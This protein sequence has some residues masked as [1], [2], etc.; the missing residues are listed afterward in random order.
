[1]KTKG[2][3]LLF[4]LNFSF[5]LF[6]KDLQEDHLVV[7]YWAHQGSPFGHVAME[8]KNAQGESVYLSYVMG[9]D[10]QRDLERF[11]ASETVTL[12]LKSDDA[13]QAYK[14][15]WKGG[16]FWQLNPDYGKAYS[17]FTFNCAHAV[18]NALKFLNYNTGWSDHH[19][20]LRPK[21]VWKKVQSFKKHASQLATIDR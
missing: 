11:G 3:L 18:S 20:A 21:K 6:A 5:A 15:W 12:P 7:H 17:I 1:M 19:F 13:F 10:L 2:F 14:E 8:V 9:N 16:P 4:F